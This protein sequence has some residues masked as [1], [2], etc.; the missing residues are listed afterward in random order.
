ME[1]TNFVILL[2]FFRLVHKNFNINIRIG[3]KCCGDK[4]NEFSD[5][6]VIQILIEGV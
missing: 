6:L 1:H 2:E 5:R 4:V 3:L